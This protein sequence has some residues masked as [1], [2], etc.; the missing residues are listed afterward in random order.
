MQDWLLLTLRLLSAV[1]LYLFLGMIVR[2]ARQYFLKTIPVARLTRLDSSF[3]EWRLSAL[4]SIGRHKD[5]AIII[6]D[7]F[8]SAHHATLAWNEGAWWLTDLNS[9]N[10]TLLQN[11]PITS[12]VKMNADEIITL[13]GIKLQLKQDNQ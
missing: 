13:G 7:D 8:V 5:N 4:N 9:T 10:G 1:I 12:A 6:D 11:Q 3:D 2:Q